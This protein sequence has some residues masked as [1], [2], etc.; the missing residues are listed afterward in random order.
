[1]SDHVELQSVLTEEEQHDILRDTVIHFLS[2][3]PLHPY[4]D[5]FGQALSDLD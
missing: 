2:F 5:F 3:D 4:V 1:M